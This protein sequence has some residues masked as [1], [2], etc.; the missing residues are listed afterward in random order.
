MD[1]RLFA[2]SGLALISGLGLSSQ[3]E[4]MA[5]RPSYDPRS[6]WV[7]KDWDGPA[8]TIH[9]LEPEVVTPKSPIVIAMHGLKRNPASYREAWIDAVKK[10]G[11][12]VYHPEFDEARF[13]KAI[14]YNLGNIGRN[15]PSSFNAIE[16]LFDAIKTKNPS[17]HQTYSLFGH[18]AGAQFVN[19]FA[20][21][22]P[23]ARTHFH[24]CANAGWYT[25]PDFETSWPYGLGNMAQAG[26]DLKSSFAKKTVIAL[27]TKDNDPN[28]ESLNKD[29][30]SMT[31]GPHRYSRGL[32]FFDQSKTIAKAAGFDFS[33]EQ[34]NVPGIDHDNTGMVNAVVRAYRTNF[35]G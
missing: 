23:E 27:G 8:L 32:Y 21:L 10:D 6:K 26:I 13:P 14:S 1:R 19:R 5:A 16:P 17:N 33:W 2:K 30:Q 15:G 35:N 11:F 18:S 22:K 24:V 31:Q 29:P 20:L 25:V 4:A 3:T 34:L 12:R 28:H 7:F 9:A